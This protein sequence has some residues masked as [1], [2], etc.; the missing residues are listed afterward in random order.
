MCGSGQVVPPSRNSRVECWKV[1][2]RPDQD[3]VKV[4]QEPEQEAGDKFR[5]KRSEVC[6]VK[7]RKPAG[8]RD[9]DQQ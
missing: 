2:K 5:K 6:D 4:Q 9:G 7:E 3:I 8:P 1:G